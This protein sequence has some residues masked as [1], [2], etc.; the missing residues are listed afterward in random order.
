[1]PGP[2]AVPVSSSIKSL[3]SDIAGTLPPSRN[4]NYLCPS[5]SRTVSDTVEFPKG[6]IFISLP[7]AVDLET[8]GIHLQT[9]F[10]QSGSVVQET[11]KL[12]IDHPGTVCTPDYYA[13]VRADM[14][15]MVSSLRAQILYK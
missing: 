2:G 9:G 10:T 4:S 5:M 1:M 3:E 14:A 11:A 6:T 13:R 12:R 7:K 8:E 15:K